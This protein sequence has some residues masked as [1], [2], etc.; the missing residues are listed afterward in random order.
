MNISCYSYSLFGTL[1]ICKFNTTNI[2][3]RYWK[4][5]EHLPAV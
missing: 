2:K 3:S 5:V 1:M 4:M